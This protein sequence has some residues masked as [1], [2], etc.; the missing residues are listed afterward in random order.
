[1]SLALA[2]AGRGSLFSKRF[3]CI[4]NSITSQMDKL[5]R[6]TAETHVKNIFGSG[7]F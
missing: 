1:M 4:L 6:L 7:A 5:S 2:D 3:N